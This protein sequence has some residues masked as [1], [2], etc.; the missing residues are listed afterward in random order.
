MW[1]R[2]SRK[3]CV[4][5]NWTHHCCVC[6]CI[7]KFSDSWDADRQPGR[8]SEC[9]FKGHRLVADGTWFVLYTAY[10]NMQKRIMR[11][12]GRPKVRPSVR[13]TVLVSYW[14]VSNQI[15]KI[16]CLWLL[17]PSILVFVPKYSLTAWLWIALF[18]PGSCVRFLSSYFFA[19]QILFGG[20]SSKNAQ[21]APANFAWL[22]LQTWYLCFLNLDQKLRSKD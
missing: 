12:S 14:T 5:R 22:H 2:Y 20:F 16:D 8:Q 9:I 4:A 15:L 6:A 19:F 7:Q 13:R 1:G 17:H 18:D 3:G 11:S 21:C 10:A